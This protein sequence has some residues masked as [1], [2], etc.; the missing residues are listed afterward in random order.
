[1]IARLERWAGEVASFIEAATVF[2][3]CFADAQ[4]RNRIEQRQ[5]EAEHVA[6]PAEVLAQFC[7]YGCLAC[8]VLGYLVGLYYALSMR[9]GW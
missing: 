1:M 3:E 5:R 7:M 4:E 6:G 9:Y 2:V 8:M